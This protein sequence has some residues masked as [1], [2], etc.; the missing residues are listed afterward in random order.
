[1]KNT[2][3]MAL[4]KSL[5]SWIKRGEKTNTDAQMDD[6]ECRLSDPTTDSVFVPFDGEEKKTSGHQ[7][8][9]LGQRVSHFLCSHVRTVVN[10][11][12]RR[13]EEE[14]AVSGG[15]GGWGLGAWGGSVFFKIPHL[16]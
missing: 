11:F 4:T 10:T 16:Q 15:R 8:A 7:E 6:G 13:N 5:L 3:V 12:V 9:I 1:M 14:P 2:T